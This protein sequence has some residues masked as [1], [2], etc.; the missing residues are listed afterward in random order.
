[1][2]KCVVVSLYVVTMRAIHVGLQ[3]LLK[4]VNGFVGFTDEF[5]LLFLPMTFQNI[6]SGSAQ[7]VYPCRA[8]RIS[9]AVFKPRVINGARVINGVR[10]N[11]PQ[12]NGHF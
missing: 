1:M 5:S 2:T 3:G 7:R 11:L 9:N 8:G 10:V 6:S 4:H 12:F